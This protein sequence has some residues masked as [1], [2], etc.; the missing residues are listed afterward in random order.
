[1]YQKCNSHAAQSERF[2]Y[3]VSIIPLFGDA[4]FFLKVGIL[5]TSKCL[6]IIVSDYSRRPDSFFLISP[7][8]VRSREAYAAHPRLLPWGEHL[9]SDHGH[10]LFLHMAIDTMDCRESEVGW[11]LQSPGFYV[12]FLLVWVNGRTIATYMGTSTHGYLAN[13]PFCPDPLFNPSCHP[14]DRWHVH[15]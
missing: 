8:S 12:L 15:S 4:L 10:C 6:I 13:L 14:Q 3:L 2:L 7:T 5:Q 11:Y 9:G 1:M